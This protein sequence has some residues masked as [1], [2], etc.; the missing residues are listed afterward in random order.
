MSHWAHTASA[1]LE[2]LNPGHKGNERLAWEGLFC[3]RNSPF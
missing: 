1:F 3:L 2:A